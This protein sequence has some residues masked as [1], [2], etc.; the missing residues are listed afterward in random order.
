MAKGDPMLAGASRELGNL[1]GRE[2]EEQFRRAVRVAVGVKR[3]EAAIK[4]VR[5]QLSGD[6]DKNDND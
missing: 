5:A 6:A 2:Y 3:N 4:A 1:S